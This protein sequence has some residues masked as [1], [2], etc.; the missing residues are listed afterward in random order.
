MLTP[1]RALVYRVATGFSAWALLA[2]CGDAR[3][4]RSAA[5]DSALSRDLT[6]AS[7]AT[8]NVAIGDT[9]VSNSPSAPLPLPDAPRPSPRPTVAVPSPAPAAPRTPRPAPAPLPAPTAAIP[10][11]TP[12]P[13]PVAE[14]PT[15]APV[16]RGRMIG[17]GVQLSGAT[18]AAICS[19][20]NR[21]GDRFVVSLDREVTSPD[22][23]LLAA[24]TPVLVEL[25]RVDS[26][27]GEMSFRLRGVQVDGEFYPAQGTVRVVDG[28]VT[29]RKVSKGGSDQGKVITGAIIG[30]ILGRVM[31]GGTKGAVIGAA[32]GAAAGTIA[33]ARNNTIERCLSAGAT[34]STTLTAPLVLT[35]SSL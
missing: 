30:G 23:A 3:P 26:T 16:P 10:A 34:L 5:I 2:A 8:P 13:T 29:E 28:A 25:A 35:P 12:A 1:R 6:L 9:A 7:S 21:P 20:A 14:A 17:E 27:T 19:L 4:E 11:P 32:G 18:N 24:G 15:P 22:G 31:G 33:A